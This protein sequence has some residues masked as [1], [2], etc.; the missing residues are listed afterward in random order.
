MGS[1][2]LNLVVVASALGGG[3]HSMGSAE[4]G[5]GSQSVSS[6]VVVSLY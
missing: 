2:A 4:G 5:M 1:L 6:L 3:K